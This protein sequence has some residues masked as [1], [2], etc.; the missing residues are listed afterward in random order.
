MTVEHDIWT[1]PSAAARVRA[2]NGGNETV[3]TVIVGD[4][5]LVNPSVTQVLAA[6]RA[7][8]PHGADHIA[9]AGPGTGLPSMWPGAVW[10]V[11]VLIGWLLLALWR[12]TTTWHLAPVLL[13]AAWPWMVGQ[14][15][16]SGDGRGAVR[17][18]AAGLAGFAVTVVAT[19][20][21]AGADLLRGPTFSGAGDV[22]GESLL[23]GGV[24][25][26]L[27]V[28]VGMRRGLRATVSRSAWVGEQKIAASDD[29]VVVE[30]NAYFPAAAIS[31]EVLAGTST[32]TV[33]PWKGVASYYT[34]MVAG[35]ELTNAAWS[36]RRP[37][38]LA[39]RVKGRVAFRGEVEVREN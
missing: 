10:T 15:L 29:V 28:L 21:L 18:V 35:T 24:G 23:L 2:V 9:G 3:P 25:A 20:G 4:T 8:S 12:P 17:V 27:V 7:E 34:V 39:R 37:L 1:D 26:F 32:K 30:G 5:A 11:A 16:R 14:D 22:V 6:L 13:A 19:L 31:P 38:P 36:Y 33:C